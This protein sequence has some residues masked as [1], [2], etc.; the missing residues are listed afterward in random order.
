MGV[1]KLDILA[2]EYAP[3][4]FDQMKK[5]PHLSDLSHTQKKSESFG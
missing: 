3:K 5:E 4:S 1:L 2:K